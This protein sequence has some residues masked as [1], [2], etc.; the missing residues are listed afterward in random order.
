VP[1]QYTDP[2]GMPEDERMTPAEL[3]VVREFLG[4]SGA[5]LA[6]YRTASAWRSRTLR[7]G[8]PSSSPAW[9]KS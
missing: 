7:R 1:E 5:A 6:A 2:P 4:M 8:P 3:K 9:S